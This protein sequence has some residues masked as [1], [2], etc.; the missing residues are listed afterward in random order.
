MKS[1]QKV[2]SVVLAGAMALTATACQGG[3]GSS[4]GAAPASSKGEVSSGASLDTVPTIDKINL[5]TDYKDVKADLTILTNRSD[6]YQTTFK[7]YIKKFQELYPNINIKYQASTKYDDDTTTRLATKNWGDI[8]SI[9]STVKNSEFADHFISFGKVSDLSKI[10]NFTTAKYYQGECYGIS[11]MGNVEGV[12]YNKKVYKDAGITTLPKTPDEFLND[13]KL[14]KSKTKAIPLYTNFA[15][16]WT[17][18]KWDIYDGIAATGDADFMNQKLQKMK[19]PFAKSSFAAGTG[20]YTVYN[21]LYEAVKNKLTEADPAT[22]DWESSKGKLNKGEIAT[23]M[24]GSWAIPQM[25]SAG[26]NKDDVGYMPFPITVN[27]KQYATKDSD[28]CFGINK[29]ASK[30]NQ[31]AAMLYVK[32][33]TE[34]SNFAYDQAGVPVVKNAELP[35]VLQNFKDATLLEDN[36]AKSGEEDI[37][38]NVNHDSE[39]SLNSDYKHVQTVVEAAMKSTKTMDWIASDWN[40]KWAK[41]QQSNNVTVG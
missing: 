38:T 12:V 26:P 24:L 5:G 17:M 35:P 13:L 28:Y 10:Y 11:T 8:C 40:Q 4:S 9:P 18:G 19:D 6:I 41:A 14:V 16:G 33:F 1:L 3:K 25:Q 20:P 39:L 27:G 37:Y 30:T 34:K 2:L 22:T 21:I 36:P 32:W 15:A 31:I 29:D 23:M 7:D